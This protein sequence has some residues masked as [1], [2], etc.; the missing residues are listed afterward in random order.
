MEKQRCRVCKERAGG[1]SCEDVC[2]DLNPGLLVSGALLLP[3]MVSS[4]VTEM[5]TQKGVGEESC[6]D[7]RTIAIVCD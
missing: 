2:W 1:L 3:H 6:E 7:L 5:E 4:S